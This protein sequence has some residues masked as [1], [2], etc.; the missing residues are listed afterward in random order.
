M[1]II[2]WYGHCASGQEISYAPSRI[3]N[4]TYALIHCNSK[5][6][7]NGIL[8][9]INSRA[10]RKNYSR[11]C[12]IG[13]Y[14]DGFS[15]LCPFWHR[16]GTICRLFVPM[17]MHSTMSAMIVSMIFDPLCLHHSESMWIFLHCN[18]IGQHKYE[19][20]KL[21]F[22]PKEKAQNSPKLLLIETKP[23]FAIF[24]EYREPFAA[25]DKMLEQREHVATDGLWRSRFRGLIGSKLVVVCEWVS[26]DTVSHFFS[27]ASERGWCCCCCWWINGFTVFCWFR[28]AQLPSR[29]NN[30]TTLHRRWCTAAFND[31]VDADEVD[32]KHLSLRNNKLCADGVREILISGDSIDDGGKSGW[33]NC[34][35]TN[36]SHLDAHESASSPEYRRDAF[37][38][39][40]FA[41][42]WSIRFVLPLLIGCCCRVWIV[43]TALA[44]SLLLL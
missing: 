32:V 41:L 38:R 40:S 25:N 18:R 34:W 43:V 9:R 1:S 42:L 37:T 2:P 35:S 30:G 31:V 13:S 11:L 21:E 36:S 22:F 20:L 3:S 7:N 27:R 23:P 12:K 5:R 28:L 33:S 16:P 14:T 6:M 29:R 19:W 44:A 10:Q 26:A 4:S 24:S 8:P 15:P 39:I 17:T